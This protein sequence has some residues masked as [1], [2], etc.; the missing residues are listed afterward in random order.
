MSEWKAVGWRGIA[1]ALE[2]LE[3][4]TRDKINNSR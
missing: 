1:T 3:R 4:H 2:I